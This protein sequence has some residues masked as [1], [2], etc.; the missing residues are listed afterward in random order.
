[1]VKNRTK[2]S[3]RLMTVEEF[4]RLPEDGHYRV[5]LVRGQLVREPP[6]ALPHG[7]TVTKLIRRIDEFAEEHGLGLTLTETGFALYRDPDTVR[8]PD[9]SFLSNERAA[10]PRYRGPY[11]RIAPD[12][13]VEVLSPSDRPRAMLE[14]V[15]E[16]LDVGS[17]L[18]WVVDPKRKVVTV[19]RAGAEPERLE[20]GDVL[21]GGD[22]LPGFELLLVK[23]FGTP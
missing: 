19:Y 1:M 14:K 11:Q 7:R 9:I 16:Y 20:S 5:E 12:L 2:S 8:A 17:R 23:L 13:A 10:R 4:A 3:N 21:R 18:V 15:N 22:V 6:P